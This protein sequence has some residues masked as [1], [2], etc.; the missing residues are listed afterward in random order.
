MNIHRSAPDEPRGQEPHRG[1]TR[2]PP[3]LRDA[4]SRAINYLRVSVTDRCNYLCTYCA[5]VSGWP[6]SRRAELLSFEELYEVI[7]VMVWRGV[8]RVR[9][10]GGEPLLRRDLSQL[11]ERV[12]ALEGV[13]EIAITTNGHLLARHAAR[14]FEAG[15]RRLNVSLDTFDP[16][17]FRRV[18]RGGE[19]GAVLEG[20]EAA[21][22]A[23]FSDIQLNAVLTPDLE[24]SPTSWSQLCREAWRRDLTPRWIEMM[25]IGGQVAPPVSVQAVLRGLE[26]FMQLS[27]ERSCSVIPRGPARYYLAELDED[28]SAGEARRR[29]LGLISPMSDPHFCDQCNRARLTARG[30]LRACLAD[31]S[32]ID[33]KSPLRSGLSGPALYPF[34][35]EA[36]SQKRPQHLM[37]HGAPPSSIMT[38]LGG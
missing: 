13:K 35:D 24:Q 22:R 36:L 20:I 33:L 12:S 8:R 37:N 27:P 6:T 1:A 14:L 15:A 38:S 10:T 11:I 23:G 16:D 31:D 34:I 30:G 29:R 26:A 25:P 17:D 5:P 2:E 28:R 4:L 3:Q 32:E 9:F 7:R 18:T 19:L 21:Q